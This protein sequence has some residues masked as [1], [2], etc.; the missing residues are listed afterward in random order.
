MIDHRIFLKLDLMIWK[1][2]KFTK[3]LHIKKKLQ[4][5]Q[6]LQLKSQNSK[7]GFYNFFINL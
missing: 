7:N 4:K 6:K 2:R 5:L 3:L 1:V